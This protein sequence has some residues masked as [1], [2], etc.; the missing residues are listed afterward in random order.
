MDIKSSYA[1]EVKNVRKL[2]NPTIKIYNQAVTFCIQAFENEWSVLKDINDSKIQCGAARNL[3]HSSKSN[4]AKYPEFDKLFHKM[5]SY[6][7]TMHISVYSILIIQTYKTGMTK[8]AKVIVLHCR[9]M[10]INIQSFIKATC[11]S[12]L[13]QKMLYCSS[14]L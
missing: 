7:T 14:F 12:G 3:I 4:K 11:I 5:P 10:P 6:C 9:F 1:V 13:I 2:F 8:A